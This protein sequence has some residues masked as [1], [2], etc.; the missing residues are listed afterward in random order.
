MVC[1]KEP[2]FEV[3]VK[4]KLQHWF[5]NSVQELEMIRV[6]ESDHSWETA[7]DRSELDFNWNV[8][9]WLETPE[10]AAKSA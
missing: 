8:I 1:G 2:P 7:D 4:C 3:P 9:E 10:T 5:T 6:D